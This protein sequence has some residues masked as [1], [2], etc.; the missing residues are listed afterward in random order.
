VDIEVLYFIKDF[1]KVGR[2]HIFGTKARWVVSSFSELE[3]VILPIFEKYSLLTTK[4][5][6]YKVFF[7]CFLS[8]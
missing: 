4:Y 7:R 8:L 6:D 1:L 5:L 2:I 3:H